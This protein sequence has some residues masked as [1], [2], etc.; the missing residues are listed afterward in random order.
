LDAVDAV[1][2]REGVLDFKTEECKS[3]R[4]HNGEQRKTKTA[5]PLGELDLI[6]AMYRELTR[7]FLQ[8]KVCL[9]HA[10]VRACRASYGFS[11]IDGTEWIYRK[12]SSPLF[13]TQ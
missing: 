1:V 12:L 9:L 13:S 4:K 5:V 8:Q 10:G 7:E 6:F 3:T 11:P 2:S